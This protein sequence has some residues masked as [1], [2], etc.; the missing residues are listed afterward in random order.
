MTNFNL[1]KMT[2]NFYVAPASS[3]YLESA[4]AGRATV[5]S[6]FHV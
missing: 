4:G 1:V 3:I 5:S 2:A 6:S